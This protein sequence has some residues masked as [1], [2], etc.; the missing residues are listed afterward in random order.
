MLATLQ[1]KGLLRR[2]PGVL[3][4]IHARSLDIIEQVG[5][6]YRSS[7]AL[8][9][10]DGVGAIITGD[11]VRVGGDVV[12]AALRRAPASFTLCARDSR[13]DLLLDGKHTYYSQDGC[14]A[15]TLDFETGERRRSCK[16]DIATMALISDALEPVD[17]VTPTVSAQDVPRSAVVVN[18][19]EACFLNSSKPVVTESVVSARDAQSQIDLAAALVGG[20]GRLRERPVFCNF[21][22]TVSPLAQDPGGIEAALE[23]ARAGVPIGAYSMATAGVTSPVTVAGSAAVVNAEVISAL[24]LIQLAEPGAKVFYAGGPATIDLKSGAYV[25]AS[26]EALWLRMAVAEMAHFYSLPSI[27]GAGATSAKMPGAQA[28]WENAISL[29]LPSL[30]GASFLFGLGLL[31]GSNLLTYE[32]IV[33]DAEVGAMVRRVLSGVDLSDEAFAMDVIA[34]L[35]S[36][37]VYLSHRHTRDHMREALS[38]ASIS[39][40]DAFG[41]WYR[42]GQRSRTEAAREQ[43]RDI[44]ANHRPTPVPPSARADMREVVAAYTTD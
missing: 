19:L 11:V 18:E 22:C 7:Q 36:T 20:K 27:V 14:S 29:L 40:R 12:E 31:D 9:I 1:A 4:R 6:R 16:E 35:G 39:D 3:E 21:V 33:L 30:A 15:F 28:A 26:P 42:K 13:N 5:I 37:G 43:V 32:Q 38:L 23:F 8:E 17:I 24:A 34:E 10:W 44:L 2:E 41:D 25:A